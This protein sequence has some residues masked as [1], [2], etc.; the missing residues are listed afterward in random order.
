MTGEAYEL[1]GLAVPEDMERLHG[2]LE[3]A[4]RENAHVSDEDVMMLEKAVMELANNVVEHGSVRR[5]VR[6]SFRLEVRDEELRAEL[7]DSGE[8]YPDWQPEGEHEMPDPLEESGR[9]LPLASAV[10]DELRYS[11]V[12][13]VNV[14]TMVRR[15]SP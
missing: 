7:S 6:W 3:Q 1:S 12:A 13:G 14:W 10:L 2:L 4:S 15:W 9:G 5:P 8:A 11:R